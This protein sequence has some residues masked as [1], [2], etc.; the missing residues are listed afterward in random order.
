M[1]TL[2]EAPPPMTAVVSEVSQV[3]LNPAGIRMRMSSAA[4]TVGVAASSVRVMVLTA[5]GRSPS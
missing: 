4:V 5:V 1:E 2:P 3:M